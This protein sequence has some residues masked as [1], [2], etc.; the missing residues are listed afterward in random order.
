MIYPK[1]AVAFSGGVDSAYLLYAAR[2][3]AKSVC[4]Y[5]V[6]SEFQSEFEKRDAMRIVQELGIELKTI[7][8]SVLDE[9]RIRGNSGMRCYYCKRRLFAAL[10]TTAR[11]DGFEVL[12][13]G[14]NASDEESDRPGMRALRELEIRSPLREC[15][16]TKEE[17]RRKS[18]EAGLFTW[19]K[20]AYACLATRIATGEE[21]TNEK[22]KAAEEA[23]KFLFSL[24]FSDFRVRTQSGSA[25]L[26]LR[27][28]QWQ[29]LLENE[30]AV[31]KKLKEHYKT[32][33][34]DLEAR[35]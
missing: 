7:K 34:L 6:E 13:D 32:V 33:A 4:A 35:K 1:V 28:E 27:R 26:Q 5:Y 19:D 17:I 23:E 21:I 9:E 25:R 2:E 18:K 8:M 12:L 22:L 20:P 29:L 16:L 10:K 31:L 3:Y 15:A 30:E 14:T 24:G 11:A